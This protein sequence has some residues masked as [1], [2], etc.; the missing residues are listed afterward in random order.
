V[1]SQHGGAVPI[2]VAERRRFASFRRQ[3]KIARGDFV[4]DMGG[5]FRG[6]EW[7]LLLFRA[8][9]FWKIMISSDFIKCGLLLAD[10]DGEPAAVT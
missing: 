1:L 9:P 7:V 10:T 5:R 4:R 6:R 2:Y 3:K 8:G